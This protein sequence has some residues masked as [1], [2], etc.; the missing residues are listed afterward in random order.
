MTPGIGRVGGIAV[1]PSVLRIER[2]LEGLV[3]DIP[4]RIGDETEISAPAPRAAFVGVGIDGRTPAPVDLPGG[5]HGGGLT[6]QRS[7][8]HRRRTRRLWHRQQMKTEGNRGRPSQD[9]C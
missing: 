6:V 7:C 5:L 4:F 1:R 9:G 3:L 8:N 2:P